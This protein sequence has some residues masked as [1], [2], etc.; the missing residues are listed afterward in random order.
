MRFAGTLIGG[1]NMDCFLC[2]ACTGIALLCY[3]L[4]LSM[5]VCNS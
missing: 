4:V 5:G 3:V 1:G 2:W